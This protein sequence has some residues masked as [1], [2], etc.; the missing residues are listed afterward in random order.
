[1]IAISHNLYYTEFNK[2]RKAGFLNMETIF[3]I[4]G[5]QEQTF[6][7]I[8]KKKGVNVI[9]HNGKIRNG[10]T[11]KG[12]RPFI[13]K[14]DCVVVLL[15]AC[16]HRA[17]ETIRELAKEEGKAVCFQEGFGASQAIEKGKE[18]LAIRA[19]A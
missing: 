9:H 8:G 17:M 6:K 10:A 5:S 11:T 13:K 15:G 18:L 16:G 7:K 19:A 4:G 2:F 14:S 3:I 12:F 1:M